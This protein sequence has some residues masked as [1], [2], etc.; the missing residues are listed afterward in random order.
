MFTK[1]VVACAIGGAIVSTTLLGSLLTGEAQARTISPKTGEQGAHTRKGHKKN[2]KP[3]ALEA[4]SRQSTAAQAAPTKTKSTRMGTFSVTAYSY[5]RNRH[6]GLSKTATGTLPQA[7]R[8]VAVDPRVIPLGSR[9]YIEGVGER[10]A[11]DTGGKIKGKK[12]DLFLPSVQECLQFGVRQREVHI[13]AK[14]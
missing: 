2:S 4:N 11:E 1:S 9:V 5:Y 14:D 7:G 8:T 10:I 13:M 3:R 6:G 12:L